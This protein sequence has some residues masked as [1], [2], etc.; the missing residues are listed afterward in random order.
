MSIGSLQSNPWA[1]PWAASQSGTGAP[2]ASAPTGPYIEISQEQA[3]FS[4]SASNAPWSNQDTGGTNGTTISP[5]NPL[6]SLASD[7]QAMLIQAQST[8]AAGGATGSTTASASP[9]QNAATDLQ[10]L[11]ADIQSAVTQSGTEPTAQ[12][13]NSNPTAPAGQTEHHHHHH[14]GGGGDASGASDVANASSNSAVVNTGSQQASNLAPSS[15]FATDIAQA[16]QAYGGDSAST[17][18]PA[19]MV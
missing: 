17:A 14:H 11:I 12:T 10:T 5:A 9:A 6:Q 18:M 19:L 13:A 16:I 7:I 1:N 15:I 8:A 2:G 3:T 4:S